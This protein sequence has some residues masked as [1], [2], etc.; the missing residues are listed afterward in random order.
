MDVW[1]RL[2]GA[3]EDPDRCLRQTVYAYR[4]GPDHQLLKPYLFADQGGFDTSRE[5]LEYL[6]DS[7]GSGEFR[8]FIRVSTKLIFSGTIR[9][10]PI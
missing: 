10:G 2:W 9:V 3:F 5:L 6:R 4:V 8:V 1:G 7:Y